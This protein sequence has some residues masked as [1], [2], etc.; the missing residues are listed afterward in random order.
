MSRNE[1]RQTAG[2]RSSSKNT[3]PQDKIDAINRV[4]NGESKAAVA[5]DIGVPE[6][7]LR[8]WCKSEQKLLSQLNNMRAS[9]ASMPGTSMAYEQ[10][11]TTSSSD[12]SNNSAV[13]GSSSRSTPTTSPSILGMPSTSSATE[14][15]TDEFEAGPS[16]KRI[17]IENTSASC[18]TMVSNMPSTSGRQPMIN[19]NDATNIYNS[20]L[21]HA[22]LPDTTKSNVAAAILSTIAKSSE[23]YALS[24]VYSNFIETLARTNGTSLALNMLQQQQQLQQQLQQQTNNTLVNGNKRKHNTSSHTLLSTMNIPSTSRTQ[25]NQSPSM[26]RSARSMAQLNYDISMPSTSRDCRSPA[27]N[28]VKVANVA[29]FTVNAEAAN[30]IEM[31]IVTNDPIDANEVIVTNDGIVANDADVADDANNAN[32]GNNGNG[33]NVTNIATAQP[34]TTTKTGRSLNSIIDS[35]HHPYISSSDSEGVI[36]DVVNNNNN[37]DDMDSETAR[38]NYPD[39]LPPGCSEMVTYCDKLLQWLHDYGSPISTMKQVGHIQQ[40]STRLRDWI[41]QKSKKEP[42][43]PN[44]VR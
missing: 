43:R 33:A 6:S 15:V 36:F 39:T 19:V 12:N 26:D 8:G 13:G 34:R 23:Y 28:L 3:T 11:L 10:I 32:N 25:S 30:N 4:H 42:H 9:G 5:R 7:T 21:Y 38:K 22:N 14:R 2:R 37:D 20:Y 44:G 29:D 31:R 16:Q 17:K 41:L 24:G 35:L 40:I 18:S 27:V 1:S